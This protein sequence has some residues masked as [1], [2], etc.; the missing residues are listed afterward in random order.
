MAP[1]AVETTTV[2]CTGAAV[3]DFCEC[4][5]SAALPDGMAFLRAEASAADTVR[6]TLVN[7]TAATQDVAS[8][9]LAVTAKR[10]V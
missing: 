5:F 2:T 7:F 6:V 3:G 4:A 10:V 8:G 1:G 9:T